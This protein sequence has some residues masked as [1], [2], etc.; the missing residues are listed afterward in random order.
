M[1]V[2]GDGPGVGLILNQLGLVPALEQV[3]ESSSS[4]ARP[5]GKAGQE[6]LH[7][8]GE[9]GPRSLHQKVEVVAEQDERQ[10]FAIGAADGA[11]QVV[12]E[13]PAVVIVVDDVLACV[14]AD[15]DVVDGGFGFDA[16]SAWPGI[17]QT[18]Q[19]D[20]RQE[21]TLRT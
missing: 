10:E 4:P 12:D 19:G 17:E 13:A 21:K 14:A 20:A 1:D 11:I 8:C 2:S 5:E 7:S 15:H 9:V 16:E 6:E 18:A 3:P